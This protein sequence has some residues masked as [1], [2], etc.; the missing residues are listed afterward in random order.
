MACPA[1]APRWQ[2]VGHLGEALLPSDAPVKVVWTISAWNERLLGAT[3]H[4]LTRSI[5]DRRFH[6]EV[7][8]VDDG[9]TDNCARDLP[10]RVIRNKA[11]RGIAASLNT[12]AQVA[13]D[14]L[15][16]D[17]VGVADAHMKVPVGAVEALARRALAERCITSSA[18][19]GWAPA[20][21][22]RAWGAYLVRRRRDLIAAKWMGRRW[23]RDSEGICRPAGEWG[24]VEVPLGAFYAFSSETAGHLVSPTGRLW[25]TVVGRWGFLMEALA[26]KCSLSGIPV[27]VARDVCTRHLYRK[28]NPLRGAA[29]ERSRNVAFATSAL[30]S[31][32]T[33]HRH[34]A[35]WC[36]AQ[37]PRGEADKLAAAARRTRCLPWSESA[38]EKLLTKIPDVERDIS[39]CS[40]AQGA[41]APERPAADKMMRQAPRRKY[42]KRQDQ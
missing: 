42:D 6:F 30:F 29:H 19:C 27:Y 40:P 10:C 18:S 28:A 16:A 34:F 17:V 20:S 12:A 11:P 5:A 15:G 24:R 33:W 23:G 38:E 36:R 31:E 41:N 9:S 4:E 26:I 2:P 39:P 8:V 21:A 13:I 7:I 14:E 22:T 1:K 32:G 25:E 3:V 37:L 35:A